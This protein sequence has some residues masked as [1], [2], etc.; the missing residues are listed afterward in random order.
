ML[1]GLPAHPLVVHLASTA[2]PVAALVSIVWAIRPLLL[3]RSWRITAL[4]TA[5]LAAISMAV[6]K[7]TGESM[8]PA[9]GLSEANP[10]IVARHAELADVATVASFVLLLVT[11][12]F[13]RRHRR[14]FRREGAGLGGAFSAG[15]SSGL[16]LSP[17]S[18]PWS[19]WAT[20]GPSWPGPGSPTTHRSPALPR[21]LLAPKLKALG[22]R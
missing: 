18:S 7:S 16:Q 3:T 12:A 1:T 21:G 15:S 8:L 6:T 19:W 20:P 13:F 17:P 11:A 4:A 22:L 10:G 14:P 9:M 2:V 5:A